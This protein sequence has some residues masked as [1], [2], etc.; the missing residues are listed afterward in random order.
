M[1]YTAVGEQVGMAQRMESVAPPGGVM[2]SDSTARLVDSVALL[3]DTEQVHIKGAEDPAPAHR[4]LGMAA[5]RR[6]DRAE[7]T[8]VG[9]QWEMGALNGV[10]DR[11]IN[12]NGSV[13]GLVVRRESARAESSAS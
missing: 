7:P 9:R 10:L 11:S 12:G 8:F 2:V 6:S 3:G 1:S 5:S 4:L 13:V